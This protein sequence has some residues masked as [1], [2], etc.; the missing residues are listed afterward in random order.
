M[1]SQEEVRRIAGALGVEPT[2]I[3]H[4]YVL[5][6][7]L[8]FLVQ[9]ENVRRYWIFKGGTALSKC[10]FPNYRFSE[11]LD[12]T[13]LTQITSESLLIIM[14][15]TKMKMQ[16]ELGITADVEKT[17]IEIIEDDYGKESFEA[18]IYYRGPLE[19]RGSPRSVQVHINRDEVLVY[20]PK[21]ARINHHFS[22]VHQLPY[23][24]IQ[25]YTLEE[26]LV[27]K[28]R[29]ISGQRRFSIARDIFDLYFLSNKIF[30]VKTIK[31]SFEK[32]CAIK[33]ISVSSIDINN[34]ISRKEEY[35]SNWE[36]NLKYLI[37]KKLRVPFEQAW[38]TALQLLELVLKNN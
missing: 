33:G 19:Y 6:V 16:Y 4:D 8:Y 20:S 23:A 14:D 9:N 7:F 3:D 12:F 38:K 32:K 15:D 28:L 36:N 31:T 34:V 37:P 5:G 24:S 11:D 1:I 13:C 18:K 30:D 21:D 29:A 22:D 17:K 2:V 35:L 27:E 26:I 25:V 10:Y